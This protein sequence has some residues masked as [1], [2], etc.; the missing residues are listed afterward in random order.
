MGEHKETMEEKKE[1][2]KLPKYE[3]F[4]WALLTGSYMLFAVG[5]LIIMQALDKVDPITQ[6][7][8]FTA[9][10]VTFALGGYYLHSYN[11]WFIRHLREK[12]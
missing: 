11:R 9:A 12:E 10:V 5:L 3:Q 6:G 8:M 2:V 4:P 7:V 1:I